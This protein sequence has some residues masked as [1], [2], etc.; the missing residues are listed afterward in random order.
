MR[1]P[2]DQQETPFAGEVAVCINH[3]LYHLGL[4]HALD[5]KN[6]CQLH[7][8]WHQDLKCEIVDDQ[9]RAWVVP[10][11]PKDRGSQVS[12]F[13]RLVFR[14]MKKNRMPYA[15]STPVG[16]F[17]RSGALKK[18]VVGL[19]C[20]SF[21]LAIFE[22][23]GVDLVQ[24]TPWPQGEKDEG[25]Q[26]WITREIKEDDATHAEEMAKQIPAL[27]Y[28]PY[29]VFGACLAEFLEVTFEDAET[30]GQEARRIISSWS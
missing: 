8:E 26:K 16:A 15:F 20:A 2:V 19:T 9:F 5:E 23:T 21:V 28:Q 18:G 25:W 14:K 4:Y 11:L 27:R 17:T 30:F 29:Q 1:Q 13:A 3:E 24:Y 12:A 22:A 10:T 7:L 6:L